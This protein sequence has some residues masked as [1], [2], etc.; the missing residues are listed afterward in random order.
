M[1]QRPERQAEEMT[2]AAREII[3][4]AWELK[5]AVDHLANLY[6]RP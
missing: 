1:E 5:R 2:R 4:A 3:E 6:Q